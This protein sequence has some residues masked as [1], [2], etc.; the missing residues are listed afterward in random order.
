M[1]WIGFARNQYLHI[2]N[3]EVTVQ[4]NHCRLHCVKTI[5]ADIVCKL[6]VSKFPYKDGVLTNVIPKISQHRCGHSLAVKI[7]QSSLYILRNNMNIHY[8]YNSLL[9]VCALF[10]VT[11]IIREQFIIERITANVRFSKTILLN[12]RHHHQYEAINQ[13]EDRLI[14]YGSPIPSI[15]RHQ[16]LRLPIAPSTVKHRG[17]SQQT[18]FP[19]QMLQ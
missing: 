8:A 10:R 17:L 7:T 5:P 18:L 11:T 3:V 2:P 14:G 12:R 15:L 13:F 6:K 1:H 19:Q 4:R 9:F 16:V